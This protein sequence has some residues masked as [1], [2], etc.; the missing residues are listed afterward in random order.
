MIV[1]VLMLCALIGLMVAASADPFSDYAEAEL[2]GS[3]PPIPLPFS[4]VNITSFDGI[5]LEALVF[6]T[7]IPKKSQPAI[8]FISSWGLNKYEYF[9]PAR[10][11]ADLGYTVVSYTARGFWGSSQKRGEPGGEIDLARSKDIAD[12]SAVIDWML[13]N[14]HADANR[15]GLSGIS[16]GGGISILASAFEPRVKR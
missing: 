9:V 5:N 10:H 7:K 12:V 11:F 15:I 3:A 1:N 8:I 6:D 16:Y 2:F 14:T 13:K 4:R